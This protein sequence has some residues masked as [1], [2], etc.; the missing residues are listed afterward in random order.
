MH[1]Y[2]LARDRILE[3]I[4]GRVLNN[5]R[6]YRWCLTILSSRTIHNYVTVP[7]SLNKGTLKLHQ[8]KLHQ[9]Q[10]KKLGIKQNSI[11]RGIIDGLNVNS[12]Y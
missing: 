6:L 10:T 5:Y 9:N 3:Y 11:T 2:L 1:D 8:I 7:Q 4:C 12:S